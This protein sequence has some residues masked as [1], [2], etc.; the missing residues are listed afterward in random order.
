MHLSKNL[1]SKILSRINAVKHKKE[2]KNKQLH[3][4]NG[5]LKQKDKK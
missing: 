3:H 5:I 1:N 2:K 4:L